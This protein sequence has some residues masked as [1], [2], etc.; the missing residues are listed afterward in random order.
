MSEYQAVY[1]QRFVDNLKRYAGTRDKVKHRV[2]RVLKDP[3]AN[4]ELLA[5]ISGK[6][7]LRGC[8][9]VRVD[10]NFRLI[11]VI[12]GECRYVPEC[13]YCF[14]EDLDDNTIVFLTVGPHDRAY[15]MK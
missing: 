2:K 14:C 7:N 8:R 3:Y 4:A 9:S 5:D 15:A 12:C 11:Y 1:E 13:V 10:R 6:L